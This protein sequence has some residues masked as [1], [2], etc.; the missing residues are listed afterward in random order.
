MGLEVFLVPAEKHYCELTTNA[1]GSIVGYGIRI[2]GVPV[3]D[4]AY[5]EHELDVKAGKVVSKINTVSQA[6]RPLHLQALQACTYYGL[7]ALFHHWTQHCYT[8]DVLASAQ[9]VD[10]AGLGPRGSLG[11]GE[12]TYDDDGLPRGQSP[13][14]Q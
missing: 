9:E 5:V 11:G 13:P 7:N 14:H 4:P 2:G 10:S 8:R 12:A 1:D 3:G 6:L